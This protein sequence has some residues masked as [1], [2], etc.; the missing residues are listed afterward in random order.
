MKVP[1][2]QLET[3]FLDAGNTLIS[4]DFELVAGEIERRGVPCDPRVLC[5]AEAAARPSLARSRTR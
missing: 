1:Y 2:P 5:R 4:I 3:L